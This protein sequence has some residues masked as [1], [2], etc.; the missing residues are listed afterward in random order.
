MKVSAERMGH[1]PTNRVRKFVMIKEYPRSVK[2][3]I[4]DFFWWGRAGI[5]KL[6]NSPY[7][8]DV[9]QDCGTRT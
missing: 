4:R 1:V 3:N 7:K 6:N 8:Q 5:S 9:D 2:I